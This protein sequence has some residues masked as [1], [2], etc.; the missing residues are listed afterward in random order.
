MKIT[1]LFSFSTLTEL[2]LFFYRIFYRIVLQFFSYNGA[3]LRYDRLVDSWV[4]GS[5]YQLVE[6]IV[7]VPL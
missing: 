1:L 5:G 3:I 4:A 7:S 2:L 6:G